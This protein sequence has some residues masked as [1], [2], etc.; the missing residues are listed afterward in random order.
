MEKPAMKTMK[1]PKGRGKYRVVYCPDE[2][3]KRRLRSLVPQLNL[4]AEQLDTH[5]CQHGFTEGRSPVTNARC[6]IGWPYTVSMDIEDFFPHVTKALLLKATEGVKLPDLSECF[7]GGAAQQ[8]LPTSPPLANIAVAPMCH[9]IWMAFCQ[10]GRFS[11]PPATFTIYADD[12]TISCRTKETVDLILQ[13]V[14]RIVEEHGFHLNANK[15]KIQCSVAGNRVI[16]GISVGATDIA[17][18]RETRRRIRAGNHQD[19][20]GLKRRTI[21]RLMFNRYRW[22][23]RLPLRLRFYW[24][25]KGLREWAK[26]KAPKAPKEHPGLL[27]KTAK[28]AKVIVRAVCGQNVAT[29]LFGTFGSRKLS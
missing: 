14:P 21:R 5:R 2:V 1:L 27:A 26:L 7:P 22:K 6:H 25:L 3:L 28:A 18:P 9:A 11:D 16:T 20:V 13:E 17:I 19:K 8:G 24:Q 12:L 15:T 29:K 10:K 23:K 4:I